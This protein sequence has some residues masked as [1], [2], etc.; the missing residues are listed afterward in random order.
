VTAA[1]PICTPD[2]GAKFDAY[3]WEAKETYIEFERIAPRTTKD[4]V[5]CAGILPGRV[6]EPVN[7]EWIAQHLGGQRYTLHVYGPDKVTGK[8]MRYDS[9]H[10]VTVAGEP[11]TMASGAPRGP[12]DPPT[13]PLD[14]S[15][16]SGPAVERLAERSVIRAERDVEQER[17][18]RRQAE[19]RTFEMQRKVLEDQLEALKGQSGNSTGALE[20][21]QRQASEQVR[22]NT[23]MLGQVMQ[24]GNAEQDRMMTMFQAMMA[25]VASSNKQPAPAPVD[26]SA[27]TLREELRSTREAHAQQLLAVRDESRERLEVLREGYERQLREGERL[28]NL[29]LE[30]IKKTTETLE[31]DVREARDSE[32]RL[33]DELQTV[34]AEALEAKLKASLGDRDINSTLE[35]VNKAKALVGVFSGAMGGEQAKEGVADRIFEFLKSDTG[36]KLVNSLGSRLKAQVEQHQQAPAITPLP[37]DY[38]AQAAWQ[39]WQQTHALPG[40]GPRRPPVRRRSVAPQMVAPP[41]TPPLPIQAQV[42]EAPAPAGTSDAGDAAV[43][44]ALQQMAAI[45]DTAVAA[46][47]A[48]AATYANLLAKLT[49]IGVKQEDIDKATADDI[50]AL[51]TNAGISLGLPSMQ[52]VRAML[53]SQ[54]KDS[55]HV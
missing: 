12:A 9:I 42:V 29:Q 45:V 15:A 23:E 18:L 3:D 55:S 19:E 43:R 52:H 33:R 44:A 34:R 1:N 13:T 6:Y 2:L 47:E 38:K 5:P 51:F 49:A 27:D 24:R 14:Y 48:P 4:G 46:N 26:H 11:K 22:A 25:A 30:S 53:E 54:D 39:A 20:V 35:T 21:L 40:A 50:L 37:P 16:A 7:S 31:H 17:S 41:A 8:P 28:H 10:N 32:R 36:G